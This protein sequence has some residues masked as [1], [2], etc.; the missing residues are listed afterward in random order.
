MEVFVNNKRRP[1]APLLPGHGVLPCGPCLTHLEAPHPPGSQVHAASGF[2]LGTQDN[3]AS[4]LPPG[5]AH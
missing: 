1:R 4:R 5:P 2:Q 3:G